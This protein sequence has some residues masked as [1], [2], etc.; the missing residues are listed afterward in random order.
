[1]NPNTNLK[2]RI[3]TSDEIK[4][5][6]IKISGG[7]NDQTQVCVV[8][9][10]FRQGISMVEQYKKSVTFYGSTRMGETDPFYQ[11]AKNLASRISKE[12]GYAIFSGGGPGIMEAANRGAVEVDGKSVGLTIKLPEKQNT[13][14]YVKEEIPFYFFFTRRVTMSYTAKA[15]LFFP[16]GFGTLD[17][18]FE[19]V[20][21]RQTGKIAEVPLILVG[22]EFWNPINKLIKELLVDKYHTLR[23]DEMQLYTI[24][25][26]ENAIMEIIKN[27]KVAGGKKSSLI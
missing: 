2:P 7:D 24:T 5:G 8:Q 14:P 23:D 20:T 11:K 12:L 15:C 1:M 27:S 18:F 10:E 17:E 26:D 9:E 16:G 3:L 4:E 21:L 25:D 6:C 22:T 19:M 13:N